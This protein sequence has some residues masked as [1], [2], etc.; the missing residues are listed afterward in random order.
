VTG[1]FAMDDPRA[2]LQAYCELMGRIKTRVALI[3]DILKD[4]RS[5]PDFCIAEL[6]QLQVRMICE[7]LAIGCL[8]AH[9]DL[10]GVRSVRLTGAYQADFIMNAL[11][12]LHPRFYPRPTRQFLKNGVPYKIEDIKE[13]FLT[14]AELLKRYHEAAAFLHVGSVTDFLTQKPKT[15]DLTA[16]SAWITKLITLL[17]QHSIYLA[18][19]PTEPFSLAFEDGEAA[20]KFQIIVQM[21]TDQSDSPTATIFQSIGKME[22][23]IG[24]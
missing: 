12:K 21:E 9:R 5:L 4:K 10:E 19:S 23:P 8:V 16:L 22:P 2:V 15:V 13:G 1:D 17:N 11:E 6:V 14:K 20:P 7:I 24:S 18:D 3:S